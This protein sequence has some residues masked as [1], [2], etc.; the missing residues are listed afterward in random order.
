[1]TKG[2]E[3][4]PHF[5]HVKHHLQTEYMKNLIVNFQYYKII[6]WTH[7]GH[8]FPF[9][10]FNEFTPIVLI[11]IMVKFDH[12]PIEVLNSKVM[13]LDFSNALQVNP[14]SIK[15]QGFYLFDTGH[16][17]FQILA[18]ENPSLFFTFM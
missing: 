17:P 7:K 14:I 12:N 5:C 18:T 4:P 3:L 10:E 8:I 11:Q 6:S 2:G 13:I 1:M 15:P 16:Q 9:K